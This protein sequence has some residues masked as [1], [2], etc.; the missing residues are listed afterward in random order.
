MAIEWGTVWE[1]SKIL[2]AAIVGA[3]VKDL[4]E[5]RPRLVTYLVHSA[6]VPLQPNP[7][8]PTAPR[9]TVHTHSIVVRNAGRSAATNVRVSHGVLPRDFAV[10]PAT[11]F[12]TQEFQGGADIVFQRLVPGQQITI[13]YVYFPPVLWSQ[14]NTTVRSDEGFAKVQSVL[15]TLQLPKG[16][17]QAVAAILL[18]GFVT[19]IYL[20]VEVAEWALRK[21]P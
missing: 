4:L 20:G 6:A 3:I 15:P 2:L 1:V 11:D 12:A 17:Q 19:L 21:L 5:R 7:Q 18:V 13:T 16:Q 9:T 8:N 10:Y 14:V